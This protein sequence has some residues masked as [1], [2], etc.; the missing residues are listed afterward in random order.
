MLMVLLLL[1][2][3]LALSIR[4]NGFVDSVLDVAMVVRCGL[5]TTAV[6]AVC[7]LCR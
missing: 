4:F 6:P 7:C 1:M 3:A 2:P 5:E